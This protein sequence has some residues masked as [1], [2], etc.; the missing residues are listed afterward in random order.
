MTE[1]ICIVCP[2]GCILKAEENGAVT[3]HSCPRGEAY[4]REESRNPVRVLTST[5]KISGALHPRCPVRTRYAVPKG[6]IFDTMRLLD[7]VTLAAPVREGASVAGPW[8]AT[9]D[10]EEV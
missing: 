4:G 5:V 9:R 3:G 6:Q 7:G 8:A 1:T 2:K 10:M